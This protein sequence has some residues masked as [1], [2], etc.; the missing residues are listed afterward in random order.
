MASFE[1]IRLYG[2]GMEQGL[3]FTCSRIKSHILFNVWQSL[4]SFCTVVMDLY[5]FISMVWRSLFYIGEFLL[6]MVALFAAIALTQTATMAK[7]PTSYFFEKHNRVM[8]YLHPP[9]RMFNATPGSNMG[10]GPNRTGEDLNQE[11]PPPGEG[12]NDPQINPDDSSNPNVNKQ[13]HQ[14]REHPSY[15]EYP[16]YER[17]TIYSSSIAAEQQNS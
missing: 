13:Y 16:T 11:P 9:R 6:M 10:S 15:K 12:P 7:N 5:L 14:Q 1:N 3:S 4:L 8:N 2:I 17:Y